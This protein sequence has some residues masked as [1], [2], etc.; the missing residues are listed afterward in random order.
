MIKIRNPGVESLRSNPAYRLVLEIGFHDMIPFVLKNIRAKGIMS[1]AYLIVNI[2]ML[3][4][5]AFQIVSG[6]WN[7]TLTFGGFLSQSIAGILGGS[8]LVIPLHEIIHGLA[9]K[10]LGAKKIIFGA[11]LQQFVFF[12]TADRH[13]VSG[14]Q[15]YFLAL[16]PFLAI[17]LITF[18]MILLLF[19]DLLLFCS[20]FL[21][22]HNLMC[23]GDFAITNYVHRAKNRLYSFDEPKEKKSYFYEMVKN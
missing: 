18:S 9:Y 17:N 13:P 15:I 3:G 20:F 19:P 2:I 7:H 14:L 8:I 1:L 22:S 10:L 11:D 4:F 12:V 5:I 23:I 21:L 16:L 6:V